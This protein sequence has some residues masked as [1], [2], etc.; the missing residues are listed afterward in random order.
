MWLWIKRWRDWVM[1]ELLPHNRL[2]SQ[3]ALHY[4]YEKA[5]LIVDNQPIPW[6]ADAVL[7]ETLVKLPADG[8]TRA[9]MSLHLPDG[10]LIAPE[11]LRP[12]N[13]ESKFRV[14]FR[15]P[16]PEKTT[17]AKINWRD[18]QLGELNLPILNRSEFYENL[19]LQMPTLTVNLGE[20][21][22]ACQSY[23]STQSKGITATGLLT[24]P[25]S[26]VPLVE[27]TIE[28]EF[29][30]EQRPVSQRFPVHF[31]TSQLHGKQALISVNPHKL[32]KRLGVWHTT[33]YLDGQ[34]LAN[35]RSRSLTRPQ[36][37]RSLR[38]SETRFVAQLYSG[39]VI[40]T[41]QPP[42][43]ETVARLGPC[44]LISSQEVGMAGLCT[45]Q[46]RA[47]IPGAIR[48]PLLQEQEI[49]ITDGPTPFVPGTVDAAE[50]EQV[51][52]FELTLNGKP[53]GLL[54]MTPAPS[55]SFTSE[56]GFQPAPEF[57]WSSVADDELAERLSHLF[58]G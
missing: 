35:R 1:N 24:S 39:E 45:L 41:R 22:V 25:T 44:F 12:E 30:S 46:T 33:W 6:N 42:D 29:Q 18:K 54:P 7:V 43:T 52:G 20:C 57:T 4:R 16:T 3:Q 47:V 51:T 36:F 49:L 55:A 27:S 40:V 50:L 53:L 34:P 11:T 48:S 28:V 32:P 26:L 31:T 58:D 5:G 2:G 38:I 37:E 19:S 10:E 17:I 14:Q 21:S 15:I 23:V 9:D 13:S 8:R 56:G